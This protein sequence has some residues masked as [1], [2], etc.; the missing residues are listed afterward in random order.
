M[1]LQ[2]LRIIDV[3]GNM[4][5]R[6]ADKYLLELPRLK[7]VRNVSW[8]AES[9]ECW[10]VKSF[11]EDDIKIYNNTR[12]N[13]T[14]RVTCLTYHFTLSDFLVMLA[15]HWFLVSECRSLSNCE[16]RKETN[17]TVSHSCWYINKY[18]G[19]GQV[20]FGI[21]GGCLNFVVFL[22]ILLTKSLRKNVS[23]VLVSNL[24]L[25]DTLSCV[26]S[27]V[28]ASVMVNLPYE[29]YMGL[30]DSMC[31]KL[32]F[33]WV[34]GQCTISITSVALTAE[35]YLCIVFSM[36]PDIRMTSRLAFVTIA[37]NWFVAVFLMSVA[38]YFKL[39]RKSYFCLP[40]SF[41]QDFPIET[42]YTL[43]LGSTGIILYLTTIPM[44]IHIYIVVKRSSQQ[45]GVKRESTLAKRIAML[46]ISNLVFFFVP[47]VLLGLWVI[48]VG[49]YE[50]ILSPVSRVI[51]QEWIPHYC[52]S[53]NS[54]LNPLVHAF[55]NDKF[56]NALRKNLSLTG[57]TNEVTSIGDT[58][59]VTAS[60]RDQVTPAPQ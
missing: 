15:R 6:P 12:L 40:I 55:R 26:Y 54:C 30:L 8:A 4:G 16:I 21:L 59:H 2:S 49:P 47:I 9:M 17:H 45:M 11:D 1:H 25:G 43:G 27:V 22:N 60:K 13:F 19:P 48:V 58:N 36:R 29:D 42:R 23:L 46:V 32:G 14:N 5:W 44:Y 18:L 50:R 37:F 52:L 34:L 35:R 56:K 3:Q 28:I 31:P 51:V 38:H 53:I 57:N 39:Y 10:L 41:Q 7:E 20:L 24:A 33:L